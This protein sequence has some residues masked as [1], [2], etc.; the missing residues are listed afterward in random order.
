[1][2]LFTATLLITTTTTEL[3]YYYRGAADEGVSRDREQ[4]KNAELS[5]I[6]LRTLKKEGR[7]EES[8]RQIGP[9]ADALSLS[10]FLAPR[11]NAIVIRPI[12]RKER[13]KERKM[14]Y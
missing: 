13:K 14:I 5:E 6:G 3:L 12:S 1:M 7:E 8:L 10:S 2:Q 11:R 9:F 4:Q